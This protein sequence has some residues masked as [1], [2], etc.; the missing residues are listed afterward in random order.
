MMQPPIPTLSMPPRAAALGSK[1]SVRLLESVGKVCAE[2]V[3]FYPPGVPLLMPGEIITEEV[4]Q[5]CQRLR[6]AGAAPHA[7]DPSFATVRV[8][9]SR[10]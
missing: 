7:N 8:V 2:V 6:E 9:S 3:S 4:V 1:R 5:V 10:A